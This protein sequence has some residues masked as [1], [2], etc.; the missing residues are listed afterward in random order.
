MGSRIGREEFGEELVESDGD[1]S[2]MNPQLRHGDLQRLG[3]SRHGWQY[4]KLTNTGHST[5][6]T[7]L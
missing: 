1:G 5:T 2:E 4:T 7:R 6:A 3:D